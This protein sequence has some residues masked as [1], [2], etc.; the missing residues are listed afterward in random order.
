MSR[1]T[2]SFFPL[3]AM[4]VAVTGC[5]TIYSDVYAPKRNHFVPPKAKPS[6]PIIPAPP[7]PGDSTPLNPGGSSSPILHPPAP[8]VVPPPEAPM[9]PETLPGM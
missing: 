2:F 6:I 4:L 8:V 9:A 3:L 5:G 1:R 7:A